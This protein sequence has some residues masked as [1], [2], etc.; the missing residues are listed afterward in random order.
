[1]NPLRD[2]LRYFSCQGFANS[3]RR[4][5][6]A[7]T[8]QKCFGALVVSFPNLSSPPAGVVCSRPFYFLAVLDLLSGVSSIANRTN[9]ERI[10]VR[11]CFVSSPLQSHL[12]PTGCRHRGCTDR[13]PSSARRPLGRRALACPLGV[14]DRTRACRSAGRVDVFSNCLPSPPVNL[15]RLLAHLP[16]HHH[17]AFRLGIYL[18]SIIL[19]PSDPG[20]ELPSFTAL[21]PRSTVYRY[22]SIVK[23]LRSPVVQIHPL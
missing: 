10:M 18:G 19:S 4:K 17:A 16:C 11:G 3:S 2:Q 20:L 23:V 8:Y 21:C 13:S 15:H 14:C 5:K 12:H 7:F 9:G 1:M 22:S 6:K